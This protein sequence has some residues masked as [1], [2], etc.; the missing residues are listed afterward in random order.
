MTLPTPPRY[1]VIPQEIRDQAYA[2]A[3]PKRALLADF[4][5][6]LSLAWKS[7]YQNTPDLNEKE[8]WEWLKLSR[9]QYFEKKA[10]MEAM[11]WLRSSHPRIGCVQFDFSRS[12]SAHG[13]SA[14]NRTQVRKTAPVLSIEEEESIN[15]LNII[16]SSSS[17]KINE[18]RKTV[19]DASSAFSANKASRQLITRM[20]SNLHLVFDPFKHG[21]LEVRKEF[22]E[23]NPEHVLGWIVKA[24]QD[25]ERLKGGSGPIGLLVSRLRSGEA[26]NAFF[27]DNAQ[28]IL[29][30]RYMEKIGLYQ[31]DCP[32]CDL[33]LPTRSAL[34][35]HIE[36]EH[37]E[38]EEDESE[39]TVF[40]TAPTDP[41][42]LEPING[43]MNAR[44]A[45]ESILGQLQMEMPRA[46]FNTWVRNAEAARFDGNTLY[47]AVRNGYAR[48]WLESRLTATVNRLLI[49]V[50]NSS[51]ITVQFVTYDEVPA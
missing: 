41:S 36:A 23:L 42:V 7:N 2:A 43:G 24:Y 26:P 51:D 19:P 20:I 8:L 10:E 31:A 5:S 34:Q 9:R 1:A 6:I 40:E 16:K 22:K 46:H 44:Q 39:E 12:F 14:E 13:A 35:T 25:R 37:P 32:Y 33:R 4:L 38:P 47:V 28:E 49:G 45:W 18:V 29:P 27:V 3:K 15:D 48:D 50:L 17:S 21:V 11:G 30:E